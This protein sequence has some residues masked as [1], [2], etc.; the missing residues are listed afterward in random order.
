MIIQNGADLLNYDAAMK[1]LDE[2]K[3]LKTSQ[4]IGHA[5][6]TYLDYYAAEKARGTL[7][8]DCDLKFFVDVMQKVCEK[9][10]F[11]KKVLD[12][13]DFRWFEEEETAS[14]EATR[15]EPSTEKEGP[16]IPDVLA[17]SAKE[18]LLEAHRLL[19]HSKLSDAKRAIK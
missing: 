4:I 2:I 7:Q 17:P 19:I 9:Q 18:C 16:E 3:D 1:A 5:V 12:G 8:A 11:L 10:S 14:T 15:L 13:E 6:N